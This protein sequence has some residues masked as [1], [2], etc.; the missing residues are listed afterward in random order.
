M[1]G[2]GAIDRRKYSGNILGNILSFFVKRDDIGMREKHSKDMF[3]LA[4]PFPHVLAT[5]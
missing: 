1:I 3:P 2:A 4:F 5:N